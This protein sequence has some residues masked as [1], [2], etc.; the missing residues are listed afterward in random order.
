MCSVLTASRVATSRCLFFFNTFATND[1]VKEKWGS[2]CDD[3]CNLL[4]IFSQWISGVQDIAEL[5]VG[6]QTFPWKVS[7]SIVVGIWE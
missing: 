6:Q 1:K 7:V 3:Y 2:R 4:I 5:H